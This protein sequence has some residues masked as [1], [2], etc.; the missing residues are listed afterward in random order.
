MGRYDSKW[1]E[2]KLINSHAVLYAYVNFCIIGIG[3]LVVTWATVVLL[4]GFVSSINKQDF[5]RLT[6]ITVIEILWLVFIT[7]PIY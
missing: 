6:L 5:W 1:K 4:G 3:Y 7:T 2:V